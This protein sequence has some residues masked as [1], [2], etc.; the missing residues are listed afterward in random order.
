MIITSPYIGELA[1]IME[2]QSK[3]GMPGQIFQEGND[4]NGRGVGE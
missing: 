2:K 4:G 3:E 1:E